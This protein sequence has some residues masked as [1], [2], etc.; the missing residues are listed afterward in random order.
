MPQE[1]DPF[2]VLDK[3]ICPCGKEFDLEAWQETDGPC[4]DDKFYCIDCL[5]SRDGKKCGCT[6]WVK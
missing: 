6:Q 1:L 5:A 3:M 4:R 2:R